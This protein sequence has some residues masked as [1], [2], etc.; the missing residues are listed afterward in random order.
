ME[1]TR[2]DNNVNLLTARQSAGFMPSRELI[3]DALRQRATHVMLD[4]TPQ[5]VGVRYQ[6]DGVWHDRSSLERE[7]GDPILEVFK[8]LAALNPQE[9]RARQSGEFGIQVDKDKY[10]CKITSQGTQT[11]ERALVQ[12]E[13]GKVPSQSLDD[14]GMRQKMQDQ[15]D[16]II[17]RPGLFLFC[18]MPANGL[19]TTIDQVLSH[20]DRFTRNFVEIVDGGK[21]HRDIENVHATTYDLSAGEGPATVLPKLIRTYPDV[22]IVR[23][24]TDLETLS[25]LCEQAGEDRLVDHQHPRQGSGRGAAAGHDAQDSAGRVCRRRDRRAQRP[26]GAQ[27]VREVQGGVSAAARGAQA[28]W[29]CPPAASK[30]STGPPHS[31]SIQNIPTSSATSATASVTWA[32]RASSSCLPSTITFARCSPRLPSWK[33][34]ARSARKLKHRSLQEEGVLLVARGVTSIQELLRVLKQ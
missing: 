18:S 21:P 12:F 27:A 17:K 19:T 24:V 29:G 3:D 16:E 28:N 34:C 9:R 4:Y 8:V 25:I 7:A 26:A 2:R 31:R 22:I 13:A 6:V 10:T 32:A 23:D 33:T 11:G 1:R 30:R 5:S 20:S 14:L 15:L